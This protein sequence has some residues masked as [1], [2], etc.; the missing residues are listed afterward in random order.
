MAKQEDFRSELT[1]EFERSDLREAW[2]HTKRQLLNARKLSAPG[3]KKVKGALKKFESGMGVLLDKH[4]REIEKLPGSKA[5]VKELY[6]KIENKFQTNADI[7]VAE[8]SGSDA[9]TARAFMKNEKFAL[10]GALKSQKRFF[11]KI[12]RDKSFFEDVEDDGD[13][14][15]D[16]EAKALISALNNSIASVGLK[17]KEVKKQMAA[18]DKANGYNGTMIAQSASMAEQLSKAEERA[19]SAE[20]AAKVA[21]IFRSKLN[22]P[23]ITL[24]KKLKEAKKFFNEESKTW[25]KKRGRKLGSFYDMKDSI[26]TAEE[27]VDQ[28]G[29][30]NDA[31]FEFIRDRKMAADIGRM[32][33]KIK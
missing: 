27:L 8:L 30:G 23:R 4:A 22:K 29:D 9:L 15:T 19:Q 25:S 21:P 1:K 26:D 14:G 12:M 5:K 2:K 3:K 18:I 10:L 33:S 16:E 28:L 24:D 17:L 6:T 11:N 20:F 31:L 7:I 32:L 13:L